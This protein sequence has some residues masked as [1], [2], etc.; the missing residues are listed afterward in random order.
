MRVH[1]R[2]PAPTSTACQKQF[3][4]FVVIK[5]H[6]ALA[7]AGRR[8]CTEL[9]ERNRPRLPRMTGARSPSIS[10]R[11]CAQKSPKNTSHWSSRAAIQIPPIECTGI[12]HHVEQ[13]V[14]SMRQRLR[15]TDAYLLANRLR[16]CIGLNYSKTDETRPLPRKPVR[17]ASMIDG[18]EILTRH[19]L[20]DF[21]DS[22][23]WSLAKSGMSGFLV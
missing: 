5:L 14:V 11:R 22:T 9:A 1:E 13:M 21:C 20:R 4:L 15:P 6:A 8:S 19:P 17:V 23:G 16:I 12:S 10:S 3:V 18:R 2:R 7:A